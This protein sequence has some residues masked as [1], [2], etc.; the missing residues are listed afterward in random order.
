MGIPRWT[1]ARTAN[2]FFQR[3]TAGRYRTASPASTSLRCGADHFRAYEAQAMLFLLTCLSPAWR[4]SNSWAFQ[5]AY[6]E[7]E[8]FVLSMSTRLAFSSNGK[9]QLACARRL[10]LAGGGHS[11]VIPFP[12]DVIF[13]TKTDCQN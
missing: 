4:Y 7:R 8:T 3:S 10:K 12:T 1:A 9:A 2:D 13:I 6:R 5:P 11:F